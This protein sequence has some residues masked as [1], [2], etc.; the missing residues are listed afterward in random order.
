MNTPIHDFLEKYAEKCILRCHMP[1]AKGLEYP[2]DITEID[3]AD[4]LFESSGIILQSEENAAK[5]FGAQK[6]LYSC[7]GSTLAIQTMLALV[8]ASGNGKSR[9]IAPRF[10]HK[11]IV[12]ACALLG[13]E[14][15][16]IY[17]DEYLSCVVKPESIEE[18]I[19]TKTL[20]VIVSGTDY[21]GGK[22]DIKA[23]STVCKKHNLPLL[24]DNAHG[25]Y[26]VFTD[27]NPLSQGASM[28]AESAHK[29]LPCI[30]G[31]AY[32][33]IAEKRFIPRSKELM[34]AFGSSSPSYLI[35]DSLDLCNQHIASEKNRALKA[36]TDIAELKTRLVKL[37]FTLRESDEVRI[38]INARK[39]GYSGFE[40]ADALRKSGLECELADENYVV[41][42]FSTVTSEHELEH[43]YSVF[44]AVE[45][46]PAL[47]A[48]ALTIEPLKSAM[49][50][51]EAFFASHC[52][53][54][55]ENAVGKICGSIVA[56]CPP[57]VP[58]VMPGEFISK[59]A[60]ETLQRYQILS[61]GV[62]CD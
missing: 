50:I 3:G 23:I 20:A 5:L 11:S 6:T 53:I 55:T 42:L 46:K 32:L 4:S 44:E 16:W 1:G 43:V 10:S 49:S 61:L 39:C 19:N 62:V 34:A 54:P 36:F 60:C 52:I 59:S 58:L 12:S 26:Q 47:E 21:Y 27:D 22:S 24:V 13:L 9:I 51:R 7:G 28:V 57:C 2:Y 41:L 56:P 40:F 38:V 14:I 17:T 15:D 33:H 29:T 37:G 35:L 45:I 25:A 18:K 8:K 30:T 48:E 31:G